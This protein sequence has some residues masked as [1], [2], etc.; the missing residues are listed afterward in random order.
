MSLF[1]QPATESDSDVQQAKSQQFS[2]GIA[3]MRL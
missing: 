3:K 1:I 2:N